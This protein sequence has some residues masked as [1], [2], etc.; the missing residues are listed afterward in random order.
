MASMS[1]SQKE[2][3]ECGGEIAFD[4]EANEAV[5]S[6]CGLVLEPAGDNENEPE[7]DSS[8]GEWSA[9]DSS[10]RSSTDEVRTTPP[11]TAAE[12]EMWYPCPTC[13]STELNQIIE[14]QLS[15]S[16]T[17]DGTYG[18]ES[19]MEEYNYVECANCSEVLLDEIGRE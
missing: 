6:D 19:S 18:G 17:D 2:C 11:E 7:E 5:C 3:P 8:N 9:F 4:K 15:V 14:S 1:G 16:A 12:W 13:G 10:E